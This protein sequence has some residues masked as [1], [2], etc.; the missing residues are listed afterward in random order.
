MNI[1][2]AQLSD[3][4]ND[5]V[6][7]MGWLANGSLKLSGGARLHDV[8]HWWLLLRAALDGT[9]PHVPGAVTLTDDL[10]APLDLHHA[11]APS[12][13]PEVMGRFLE[14]AGYLR[15]AGLFT[16]AEMDAVSAD[17]DRAAPRYTKGD[18]RS[19]WARLN[20]GTDALVRMQAFDEQSDAVAALVADD[21]LQRL[22]G[23]TGDGHRW[24]LRSDNRI[25]ALFKPIGVAQGISDVPW[26][27]D[28][29]LG[30]HSYDCCGLNV[31]ISVTGAD[32]TSGQLRVVAGSHRALVWPA[33]SL[34]P[35]LDLPEVDLP[36]NTGDITIHLSCTLHM[37]QPPVDR[38]RRV[39][40][41]AFGLPPKDPAA[42]A[43]GR[44]RLRAVREA[45]PVTVSQPSH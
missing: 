18:G 44:K 12:D 39:M 34:Q 24:G 19:W 21:R 30:R 1:D 23:L 40:Y 42:A 45:A 16:E 22:S 26:H 38:P 43:A 7:P 37:A 11:F 25:E 15:I 2:A 36:T 13:P 28:C 41:T 6:T 5:Q 17:M 32:A 9:T 27:K 8:L 10:G 14:Q 4:V 29:S 3:L 35:G 20:D 33:P 31:G